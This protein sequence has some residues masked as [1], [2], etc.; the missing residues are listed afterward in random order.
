MM[1]DLEKLNL[2]VLSKEETANID[3]GGPIADFVHWL[4]CEVDFNY[5]PNPGQIYYY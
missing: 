4:K 1:I 3:G 2:T 5:G